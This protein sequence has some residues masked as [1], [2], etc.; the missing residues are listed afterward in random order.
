MRNVIPQRFNVFH[1][2]SA[3]LLVAFG[4]VGCAADATGT[5]DPSTDKAPASSTTESVKT[6]SVTKE[7]ETKVD[8][9]V[10]PGFAC[11]AAICN[12]GCESCGGSGGYCYQANLDG[13]EINVCGCRRPCI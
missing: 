1:A 12:A 2:C 3:A 6:E 4:V 9:R 5:T 10:E 8:S 13:K 7:P 11:T